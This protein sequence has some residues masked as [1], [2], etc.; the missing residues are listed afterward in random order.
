MQSFARVHRVRLERDKCGELIIPGKHGLIFDR[1]DG[2]WFGIAL[3]DNPPE[4]SSKART[5][6]C[7]R[8]KALAAGLHPQQLGD[9]ES[10]FL[11]HPQ[12]KKQC[13][14]AFRLIGVRRRRRLSEDHRRT[15]HAAGRATQYRAS[16]TA[17]QVELA[18]QEREMEGH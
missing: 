4:K 15:L 8:K 5:L 3:F 17:L 16:L 7:Q 13:E 10:I 14:F 18:A 12:D 9:C 1:G 11:F 2:A 6:L